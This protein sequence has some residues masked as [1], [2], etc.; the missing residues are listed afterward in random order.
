MIPLY[1]STCDSQKNSGVHLS[2]QFTHSSVI[3]KK[4]LVIGLTS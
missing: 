4:M 3:V 1:L 2:H